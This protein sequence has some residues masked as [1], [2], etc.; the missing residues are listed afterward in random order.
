MTG[1]TIAE[2]VNFCNDNNIPL[3]TEL[4]AMGTTVK[5]IGY[6]KAENIVTLDEEDLSN[7][8]FF[9]IVQEVE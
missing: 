7:D 4:M 3:N 5:Y 6:S 2:L 1:L 9:D 8:N